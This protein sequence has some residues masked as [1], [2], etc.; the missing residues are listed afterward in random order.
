MAAEDDFSYKKLITALKGISGGKGPHDR[1][2]LD[3]GRTFEILTVLHGAASL[4]G[5]IHAEDME[6]ATAALAAWKAEY[7]GDNIAGIVKTLLAKV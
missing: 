6:H 5:V 7:A 4:E 1:I 3:V 2:S